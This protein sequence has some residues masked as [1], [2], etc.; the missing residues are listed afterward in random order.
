LYLVASANYLLFHALVELFCV[1]VAGL[2]FTISW[3]TRDQE[4]NLFPSVIGT[5]Y[6]FV[7]LFDLLHTITYKG[8][9][10]FPAGGANLATQL[11]VA[12]RFLEAMVL[13]TA[14]FVPTARTRLAF[15]FAY[16]AYGVLVL[17]AIFWRG[18]FPV[19]YID[20]TGLTAFKIASEY[21]IIAILLA[22]R[23]G[24]RKRRSLLPPV[25]AEYLSYSI[26]VTIASEFC[27][28]LYVNVYDLANFIG[29][30]LK[31]ASYFLVLY[32]IVDKCIREP[33]SN[34]YLCLYQDKLRL[35]EMAATDPLTGLLNRR[36]AHLFIGDMLEK[37]RQQSVPVSLIMIDIDHFK[38]VNDTYGHLAGDAVLK[39][40][41]WPIMK[42]IR[43]HCDVAGRIG[44]EEFIVALWNA[45]AAA[46]K[47]AAERIRR[48][49]EAHLFALPDGHAIHIT[50]SLGVAAA[51]PEETLEEVIARADTALYAAKSRGRN[52][53]EVG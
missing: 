33:L 36:A 28:T 25:M 13:L 53:T 32:G 39:E 4:Y 30:I 19:C 35:E 27:F 49:T 23:Y 51:R 10:I 38:N 3:I 52:R 12:G 37:A 47:T 6:V 11:W 24:L 26:V 45:D 9:N 46:A 14:P 2:I 22:A 1:V 16:V 40:L 31:L 48:G 5:G 29:H 17:L 34:L 7:G 21:A 44:G 18:V 42:A 8:M 43:A 41:R 20:G 50:L 15:S